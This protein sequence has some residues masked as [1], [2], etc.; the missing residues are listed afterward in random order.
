[1]QVVAGPKLPDPGRRALLM[2]HT[3]HEEHRL[4]GSVAEYLRLAK[5]EDRI[6]HAAATGPTKYRQRRGAF[7]QT[8]RVEV[9]VEVRPVVIHEALPEQREKLLRLVPAP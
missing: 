3:V 6:S 4:G 5:Q 8:K 2:A 9:P 1:M 7:A